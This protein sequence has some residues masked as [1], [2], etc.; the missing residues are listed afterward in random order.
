MTSAA[1]RII[2]DSE[3][4][5]ILTKSLAFENA[6]SECQRLIRPLKARSPPTAAWIR[7]IVDIGSHVYGANLIEVISKGIINK[8]GRHFNCGKQSHLKMDCRQGIP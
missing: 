8:N 7:D 6:N 3:V 4:R 2:S 1:N 5:K